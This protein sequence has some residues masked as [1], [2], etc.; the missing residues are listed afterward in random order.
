LL[1]EFGV[2]DEQF[3]GTSILFP[4]GDDKVHRD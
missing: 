4:R 1:S 2:E 3:G